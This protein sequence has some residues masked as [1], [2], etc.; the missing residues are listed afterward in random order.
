MFC[1]GVMC[2]G[3]NKTCVYFK[4]LF[5]KFFAIARY[6]TSTNN[7]SAFNKCVNFFKFTF[8]YF[9]WIA[10]IWIIIRI[11]YLVTI[12]YQNKFCCG[13]STVN[14]KIGITW[15]FR[16][17]NFFNSCLWMSFQKFFIFLLTCKKWVKCFCHLLFC[18]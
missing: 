17:W 2:Q 4:C 10:I 14:S 1:S 5:D 6:N 18:I 12:W 9:N 13:A 11:N 3:F 15:I 8:Y 16:N 7:N